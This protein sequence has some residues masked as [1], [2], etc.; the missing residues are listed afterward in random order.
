LVSVLMGV[1][2]MP[3][4]AQA[5]DLLAGI[6]APPDGKSLG[7]EAISSGGQQASYSTSADPGAVLASYQEAL[8]GAGWTVTGSGGAGGAYGG[9][10]G[11][12]ATNGP[13]YL[14]INAGGPAGRTFVHV[15]VWPA[16]PSNDNCGGD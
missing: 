3:F 8:P 14:S 7:T 15:C 13:K 4:S 9:G 1:A 16:K 10:G 12:Q 5:D 6:P 11:L 2:L